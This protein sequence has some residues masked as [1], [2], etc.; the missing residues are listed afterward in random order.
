MNPLKNE[1]N[2]H[3][4]MEGAISEAELNPPTILEDIFPSRNFR[5]VKESIVILCSW[6]ITIKK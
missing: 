4:F 3:I 2:Y 6:E 1:L 5:I